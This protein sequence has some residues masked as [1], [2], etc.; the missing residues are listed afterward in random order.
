MAET[1]RRSR[2]GDTLAQHDQDAPED[3]EAAMAV[4]LEVPESIDGDV[5]SVSAS[6]SEPAP[7]PAATTGSCKNCQGL[8]GHF[9]NS[10]D[11]ITNTYFLP[12]MISSYES[13]LRPH[14]KQKAATI[15]TALEGW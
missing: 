7:A 13:K 2:V 6:E 9:F 1:S 14:G 10:W 12:S 4:E 11:R 5:E 3:A 15:G 8:V